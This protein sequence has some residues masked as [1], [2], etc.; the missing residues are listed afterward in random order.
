MGEEIIMATNNFK[1]FGISNGANVTSQADYEALAAL[2]TGFTA[3]KASSAQVNKAL[4][5]G[6][7]MASVLAQFIANASGNDVLDNGD[8]AT[9]I[10]SLIAALKANSAN[11]FLQK[12]NNLVEIKNTGTAAQSAART[13][14]GL[15]NSATL[16]TGTTAGTVAAGNDSRITGAMQK[17]NNLSDLV[18]YSTARSN[19]GLKG[20]ALLDVGV[21]VGTV[22]AGDDSRIT[23]AM[24]KSNNL[25]DLASYS[26]A[27][28]N[29]GLKGAALLDVGAGA[30]T[31]A[32][33]DDT[34]ITGAMQKTNNLSDL[35]NYATA[36]SNLGLGTA[37]SATLGTGANQVPDMNSFTS[38]TTW[39]KLPSGKIV[40]M[41]VFSTTTSG[42]TI[43]NFPI[44]FPTA[45][46]SVVATQ[47][48]TTF[49]NII[50][51]V[52]VGTTQF[53]TTT[54][55]YNGGAVSGTSVAYI[56]IGD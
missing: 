12:T 4:R 17:S 29:M 50:G 40:Q 32:A 56:A 8:T 30:G 35:P 26:T 37:A 22:A 47:Q 38:S 41:G 15:G 43:I 2:L 20:A 42:N 21:T 33:G 46:R 25:S 34:R 13:N 45:C 27:R 53:R 19:M 10:T 18:S 9:L 52:P 3:G 5:Q 54:W 31:V 44:P 48:D 49:P 14:L 39:F 11:D 1:P 24:Q 36:R 16:N 6:T 51:C 7:V 55:N 28:S 23:G